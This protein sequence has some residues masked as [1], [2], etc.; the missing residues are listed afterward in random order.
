MYHYVDPTLVNAHSFMYGELTDR[1]T[2]DKI[3]QTFDLYESS[4]VEVLLYAKNS[5]YI[6][7][8]PPL[9]YH[10]YIEVDMVVT[11]KLQI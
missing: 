3:R 2:I 6:A 9:S 10:R 4:F 11:M 8:E 7:A 5:E 1:G